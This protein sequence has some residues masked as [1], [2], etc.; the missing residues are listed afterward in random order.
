MHSRNGVT[1]GNDIISTASDA[2]TD[3]DHIDCN[4]KKKQDDNNK[5]TSS[6]KACSQ[7]LMCTPMHE[8]TGRLKQGDAKCGAVHAGVEKSHSAAETICRGT[9]KN[10]IPG[11]RNVARRSHIPWKKMNYSFHAWCGRPAVGCSGG[12]F[13]LES[14]IKRLGL[15]SGVSFKCIAKALSEYLSLFTLYCFAS[16]AE[17]EQPNAFTKV[18]R[19]CSYRSRESHEK[20]N[21]YIYSAGI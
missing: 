13:T 15:V 11:L 17:Q 18:C 7:S 16:S 21:I 1:A 3:T 6:I 12:L 9:Q 14:I 20:K 8:R 5:G 2:I 4:I 10:R 19:K